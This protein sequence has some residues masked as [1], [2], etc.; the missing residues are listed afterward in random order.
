MKIPQ[1]ILNEQDNAHNYALENDRMIVVPIDI[2]QKYFDKQS[3]TKKE[4]ILECIEE[5][6]EL[7][8]FDEHESARGYI[9]AALNKMSELDNK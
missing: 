8:L 5:I 1:E 7:Q 6:N 9:I 3:V 4:T 2:I